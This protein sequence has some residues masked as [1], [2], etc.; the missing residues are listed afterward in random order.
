MDARA[1]RGELPLMRRGD[2][3][4]ATRIVRGDGLPRGVATWIVRGDAATP[5]LRR[6]PSV[7]TR[8]RGG[9]DVDSPWIFRR[10]A[11]TPWLTPR[12]RRGNT[13]ETR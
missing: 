8:R 7:A 11:A 1:P 4:V 13:V 12:P 10:D 9:R 3:A 5:W 2:A 6:G